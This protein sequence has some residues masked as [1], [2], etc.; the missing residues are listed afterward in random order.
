MTRIDLK[1]FA[2]A[3]TISGSLG[4]SALGLGAGLAN[5]DP[6]TPK[7]GPIPWSQDDG[8]GHGWHGHGHDD[9][10]WGPGWRGGPGW[11]G[12]CVAATDPSGLVT[13]QFCV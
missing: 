7:T 2:I 10:N 3:V 9:G 11:P 12:G 4:L 13:G 6:L 8:N 5:A 1:K